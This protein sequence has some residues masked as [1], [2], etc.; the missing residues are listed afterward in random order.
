MLFET[1]VNI[2]GLIKYPLFNPSGRSDPPAT[3]VA[4]S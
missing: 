1:S 3:N 2:V 4:P